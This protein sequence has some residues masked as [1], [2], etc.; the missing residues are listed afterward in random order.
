[1]KPLIFLSN[2]D[3][4]DMKGL[5]SLIE[6]VRPFGDLVVVAPD[7]PRSGSGMSITSL[8]PVRIR[9]VIEEPGLTLYACSG[10]PCDC[11]KLALDEI[12]D[13]RP[14]LV[15]SG[16]NHGDNAS[17]N[18][19]YSGT[20][21]IAVEAAMKGIPAIGFSSCR[22]APDSDFSALKPYVEQLVR[23]VLANGMPE[24]TVLNVNFPDRDSFLGLHFCRMGKATWGREWEARIDPRNRPY[25]WLTGS[26]T[27][28]EGDNLDADHVAMHNGYVAVTPLRVDTTDYDYLSRLRAGLIE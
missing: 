23:H 21:S 19:W 25:Y 24:R 2:D 13:A 6:M 9:K 15:L 1:M 20:L 5:R 12:L 18:A 22:V 16:I 11:M 4:Y 8:L 14:A 7:G 10:S 17:I 26:F 3:G 27:D 28:L